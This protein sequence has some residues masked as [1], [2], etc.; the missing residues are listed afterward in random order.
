MPCKHREKLQQQRREETET[1][2][3]EILLNF[4]KNIL[5]FHLFICS[6]YYTKQ[7][8]REKPIVIKFKDWN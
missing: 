4:F 2:H 6:I 7:K 5:L 8:Q 1:L 3:S